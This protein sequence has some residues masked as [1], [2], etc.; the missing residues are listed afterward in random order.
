[1]D[2]VVQAIVSHSPDDL[3]K[4][5]DYLTREND[6]VRNDLDRLPGFLEASLEPAKHSLGIT[7][8][9]NAVVVNA[10]EIAAAYFPHVKALLLQ[11][12]Y[13]QIR[14]VEAQFCNVV[15]QFVAATTKADSLAR[16]LPAL[17]HAVKSFGAPEVLTP[18]H[19]D[20]VQAC[21]VVRAHNYA[22][23]VVSQEIVDVNMHGPKA[24]GVEDLLVYFYYAALVGIALKQFE[25]VLRRL[26][27]ILTVPSSCLSSVQVMAY[28]KL[29]LVSLLYS[30]EVVQLPKYVPNVVQ[31]YTQSGCAYITAIVEAFNKDAETLSA[32]IEEHSEA[33][34]ADRNMGLAKQC[35]AAV[36]R[37]K[38]R[39]LTQTYL[40][41]SLQD[42]AVKATIEPREA[43]RQLLGMIMRGEV[44]ARINEPAQMVSFRDDLLMPDKAEMSEQIHGRIARL[45]ATA[46]RVRQMENEAKLAA[47][48]V[49]GNDEGVSGSLDMMVQPEM[50][51]D[52][53]GGDVTPK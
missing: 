44:V 39:K 16:Y 38:V 5:K 13:V 21:V 8:L 3:E 15:R 28:K 26:L 32:K 45:L 53:H 10:G 4:L 7:L 36:K 35:L 42:I 18:I 52:Y 22:A 37:Q 34:I 40:T 48:S 14:L 24:Q 20:F 31:R 46:E 17:K 12:D 25:A 27:T 29:A 33:L 49:Q 6:R 51:D 9:L 23:D 30:G 47:A 41:L 2:V 11:G 50:A 19:A 1:M 43:E